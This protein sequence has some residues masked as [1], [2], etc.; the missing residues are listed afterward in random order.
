MLNLKDAKSD[1]LYKA[2]RSDKTLQYKTPENLYKTPV[3][4]VFIDSAVDEYQS[5]VDS[6]IP[7]AEVIILDSTY[8]GIDQIT[9]V[10]Q[11]RTNI[12]AIHIVSHGSPGSLQLGNSQLSLNTLERYSSQLLTW[13]T[14][15][16]SSSLLLYGCNVAAGDAGEEFL[17][18]LHQLTG[19]NIAASAGR[20]GNT[21]KG[22][23]WHLEH[24]TGQIGTGSAFLPELMQAY[25]GVFEVSF[26]RTDFTVGSGSAS[27]AVGDFDSDG[28]LDLVTANASSDNVSV[29][30]NDGTGSFGS[31]TNFD[32]GTFPTSVAVGDFNEDGNLDLVT[33]NLGQFSLGNTVSVLLGNGTGSF[34]SATNFTVGTGPAAV[35]VADFNGDGNQDLAVVTQNDLNNQLSVLLGQGNGNFDPATNLNTG[36][37]VAGSISVGDFNNDGNPDVVIGSRGSGVFLVLNNGA[38]GFNLPA[39]T[40]PVSSVRVDPDAGAVGDF[41]GDGNQDLVVGSDS[42]NVNDIAVLLG[43]GDGSF[44]SPSNFTVGGGPEVAVGDFDGDGNLDIAAANNDNNVSVLLGSGDGN[45]I[46]D[47]E[48]NVGSNPSSITVGDFN[49]DGKLD[50]ATANFGSNDVSVLLNTT[51]PTFDNLTVDTLI[52]E[53]DGDLSAGDVSLREAIAFTEAGGTINFDSNLAGGTISLTQGELVINQDLTINGL[54]ANNLTISGNNASRVFNIDDGN[55]SNLIDVEI[56]GLTIAEGE[57]QRAGGILNNE[58]LTITNSAISSNFAADTGGGIE[59]RGTLAITYSTIS[60]NTGGTDVGGIEN[61]G[62]LTIAYSTIS[63]NITNGAF[64]GGIR[65]LGN[66]EVLN[67]TISGN[68]ARG[69]GGGISNSGTLEVTNSTIS[70]NSA[71]TAGGGI[72]GSSGSLM[73]TNSTITDNVA[74][75]DA[76]NS[77]DPSGGDDG[78]GIKILSGTA[79]VKNT[80]IA[81]NF[82][83]PNNDGTGNVHPDVSGNFTITDSNLI[84]DGTGSTGFVNGV[85]ENIVGSSTNPIDPLLGPLQNNGGPTFTHALLPGSP[86][87]NAGNNANIPEGITTDQRGEPRI[88]GGT[89]DIGAFEAALPSPGITRIGTPNDDNLTGTLGNDTIQGFNS[90]DILQGLAG[91]DLLDGGDGDDRLFGGEDNDTLLGGSGQDRLFGEAGD[92]LL[93]GGAGD[94][95]LNGGSGSDIFVLSTEGK[96]TIVDFEDG[97]DLLQLDGGLTFGSLSIFEQNGDTWITTNNNQPLAFLTGVDSNL[98][99]ATDFSV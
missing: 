80:I 69:A 41:N 75:S 42:G 7:E 96:N 3:T 78:G 35:D 86:A 91:D 18:R 1:G 22:G 64:A 34:G 46:E 8:D 11:G 77:F 89:V 4:I 12:A 76:D 60:D 90:Q 38:G 33:S 43:N 63:D 70:G 26:S 32:V 59:N 97:Q 37:G 10:L 23:S 50:I 79:E 17:E 40:I 29:L 36:T 52:D 21:A 6:A 15:L 92:D 16:T 66:L 49:G 62:T 83:I 57:A 44:G 87:I 20:V 53:N 73:V 71:G 99:T 58:N 72:Y 39:Q 25:P 24:R 55:T 94:N 2:F 82:D 9:N 67:S 61:S 54:G 85:N 74:N 98:I 5:L 47:G 88:V 65:N 27:V 95:I 19:A 48:F 45:F 93:D 68:S 84:G 51:L 56:E 30:L 31:A 14:P 81:G 28:N 13:A